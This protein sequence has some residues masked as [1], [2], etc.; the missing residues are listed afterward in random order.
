MGRV[1]QEEAHRKPLGTSSILILHLV[2]S[3]KCV[4]LFCYVLCTFQEQLF[5]FT[6][7]NVN[8]KRQLTLEQ[9]RVSTDTQIFFPSA[10]KDKT[11]PRL[12][13]CQ[14]AQREEKNEDR[15]DD[16]LPLTNS[17]SIFSSL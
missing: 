14:L 15:Y 5:Y 6:I 17:K 7:K 2:A 8:K 1:D 10:T 16:P 11:D 13:P 4:K 3:Q 12:P 9:L